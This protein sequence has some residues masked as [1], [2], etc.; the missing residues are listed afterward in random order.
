MPVSCA[1]LST[2]VFELLNVTVPV[3]DPPLVDSMN[4]LSPYVFSPGLFIVSG[5]WFC[6]CTGGDG[7]GTASCGGVAGGVGVGVGDC[8][9][10]GDSEG[11]A[12]VA[13]G[14]GG[15]DSGIS[16]GGFSIG[17]GVG[18]SAGDPDDTGDVGTVGGS[19]NT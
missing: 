3:P 4:G 8:V 19:I 14:D 10:L 1:T 12:G 7:G 18:F 13:A 16:G 17:S 6:I 11:G 5:A 2:D 15:G 9:G